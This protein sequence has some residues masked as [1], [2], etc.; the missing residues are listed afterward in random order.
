MSCMTM[1]HSCRGRRVIVPVVPGGRPPVG[2][3]GCSGR[4]ALRSRCLC[5][6]MNVQLCGAFPRWMVTC[7]D[8][9]GGTVGGRYVGALAPSC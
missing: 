5:S 1:F 6:T 2:F 9:A 7:V 8:A 3:L 4:Y